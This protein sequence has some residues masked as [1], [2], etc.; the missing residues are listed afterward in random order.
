MSGGLPALAR[1]RTCV[2]KDLSPSYLTVAPVHFSN[3]LYELFCGVS[4]GVT[5]PV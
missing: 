5:M 4:S 2:S 1:T 3:G